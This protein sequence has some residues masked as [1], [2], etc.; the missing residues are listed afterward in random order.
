M[1]EKAS[2][3]L[4][5]SQFNVLAVDDVPVNILLVEK[6]LSRYKFRIRSAG[7]GLE[8][9][10]EVRAEKPDLILLDLMMPIMDGFEFLRWLKSTP[11]TSDIR[12]IVLSALNTNEDIVKAYELGANDFITKPIPLNKLVHAVSTQLKLQDRA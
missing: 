11:E 6:M 8:A 1:S 10:R 9:V 3:E 2:E 5:F 12:V 7:N 4:D